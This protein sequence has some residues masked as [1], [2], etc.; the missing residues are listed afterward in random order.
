VAADVAGAARY[1]NRHVAGY[2]FVFA[3]T[4]SSLKLLRKL[5]QNP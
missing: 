2:P 5:P 3:K 1:Q 4:V